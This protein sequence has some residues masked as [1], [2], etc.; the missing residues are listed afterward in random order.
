M[1]IKLNT[2]ELNY[3]QPNYEMKVDDQ[4]LFDKLIPSQN[5]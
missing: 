2:K 1:E 4:S 5:S 3:E